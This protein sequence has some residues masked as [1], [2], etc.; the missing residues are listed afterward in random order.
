MA[1]TQQSFQTSLVKLN[2]EYE[3]D[4]RVADC[5]APLQ[6]QPRTRSK[7]S[8]QEAEQSY[9]VQQARLQAC[10]RL[11]RSVPESASIWRLEG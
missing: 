7:E 10:I 9:T 8:L 11:I 6:P 5:A 1:A 4:R 2:H 3:R